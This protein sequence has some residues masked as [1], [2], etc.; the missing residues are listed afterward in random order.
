MPRI[1]N[2][3]QLVL[4]R[5]SKEAHYEHIDSLFSGN[6]DWDL[7][8]THLPDMLRV[9][10]STMAASEAAPTRSAAGRTHRGRP[11]VRIGCGGG[12]TV[13]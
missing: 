5:P 13:R 11:T 8:A 4:Y 12:M 3:K 10:D 1:R 9:G 2:W 7:I 6:V